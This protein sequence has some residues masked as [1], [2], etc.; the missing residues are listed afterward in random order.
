MVGAGNFRNVAIA[1]ADGHIKKLRQ[2]L[3]AQRSTFEPNMQC[4]LVRKIYASVLNNQH[5]YIYGPPG[6]GKTETIDRIVKERNTW[7]S[8]SNDKWMW[9]GLTED[10][11]FGLFEDFDLY[12]FCQQPQLLSIMDGK[13][14]SVSE[15]YKNDDVKMF[16]AKFLFISNFALCSTSPLARRVEYIDCNH[17]MYD[18][19]GCTM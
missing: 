11:E 13:P 7:R 10:H 6:V 18:C 3:Q 1:M 5:V 17:R 14:V 4:G 8:S 15:K 2:E 9:S 19:K 16:K 12:S